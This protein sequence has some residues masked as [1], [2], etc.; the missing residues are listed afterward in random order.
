[1]ISDYLLCTNGL[2]KEGAKVIT[3]LIS[4]TYQNQPISEP[5]SAISRQRGEVQ[6]HCRNCILRIV[7]GMIDR[8]VLPR[9]TSAEIYS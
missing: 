7:R 3:A 2:S 1:M 8:Y 6:S 9:T 4:E 5:H